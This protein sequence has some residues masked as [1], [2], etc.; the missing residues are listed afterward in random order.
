MSEKKIGGVCAGF[1]R[2]FNMDVTLMRIIWLLVA[3]F[4]GIGFLIYIVLWIAMPKDSG[5]PA[6][7]GMEHS[8]T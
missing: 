5:T 8:R 1:A 4:S 6:Q 7:S 2:Y 3:I